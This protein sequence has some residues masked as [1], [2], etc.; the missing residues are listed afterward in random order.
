MDYTHNIW[1]IDSGASQHVCHDLSLFHNTKSVKNHTV[2][3]PNKL[4]LPVFM[5]GDVKIDYLFTLRGVLYVPH[6]DLNLISV[7]A[8]TI[9]QHLIVQFTCHNAYIQDMH[10]MKTIGKAKKVQNL[11]VVDKDGGRKGSELCLDS[12]ISNPD[13]RINV[14][15]FELW[16]K[17]L[18]HPS[19]KVL[20]PIKELLG[21][22]ISHT[23]CLNPCSVCPLAKQKQLPFQSLNNFSDKSFSLIHCDIWGP[24]KV[25]THSGYRYFAIIVD[26]YSRYTWVY[27]LR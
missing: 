3:L 10:Q 20:E 1:I 7:S 18:G 26:D 22:S 9:S 25:S 6:F 11:Y 12:S 27:L 19:N 15:S 21:V 5:I 2:T 8:L 23:D 4:V 13:Y 14:V 16:H 17:R 24:Y